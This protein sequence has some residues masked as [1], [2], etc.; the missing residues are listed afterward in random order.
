MPD[1][2]DP[3]RAQNYWKEYPFDKFNDASI[4]IE[5]LTVLYEVYGY[6]GAQKLEIMTK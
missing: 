4:A 1:I 5:I 2:A 6:N 3:G